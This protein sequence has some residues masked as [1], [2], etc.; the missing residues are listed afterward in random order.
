MEIPDKQKT[1][2]IISLH[3]NETPSAETYQIGMSSIIHFF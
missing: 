3:N 1:T 2:F